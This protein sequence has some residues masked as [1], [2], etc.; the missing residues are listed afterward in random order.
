VSGIRGPQFEMTWL[1]LSTGVVTKYEAPLGVR[2]EN[3][4]SQIRNPKSEMAMVRKF[5]IPNSEFRVPSSHHLRE[6]CPSRHDH[7]FLLLEA[8]PIDERKVK[9]HL[10]GVRSS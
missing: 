9:R 1:Q 2:P 5:L 7:R 6:K 3:Q 10:K 4:K 8:V